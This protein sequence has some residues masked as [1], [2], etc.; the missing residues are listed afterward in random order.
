M[1][2][3]CDNIPKNIVVIIEE[4]FSINEMKKFYVGQEGVSNLHKRMKRLFTKKVRDFR[5][6]DYAQQVMVDFCKHSENGTDG[7]V[8][9]VAAFS[10]IY[11]LLGMSPKEGSSQ[12]QIQSLIKDGS[13][14]ELKKWLRSK[15]L[16]VYGLPRTRR[17]LIALVKEELDKTS[18]SEKPV[19]GAS[20][21][22]LS[23]PTTGNTQSEGVSVDKLSR[24]FELLKIGEYAQDD[25]IPPSPITEM[26][27]KNSYR[28]V[29]SVYPTTYPRTRW[30]N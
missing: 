14:A 13:V 10:E 26:A 1:S 7:S 5:K 17:G 3:L 15:G 30:T 21:T 2:T 9:T 23:V 8:M 12:K 19:H 4:Q 11:T 27:L 16:K 18:S 6:K 28:E 20:T 22:L 24:L 25:I 29:P